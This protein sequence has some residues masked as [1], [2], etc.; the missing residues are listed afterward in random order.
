MQ[1]HKYANA[2]SILIKYLDQVWLWYQNSLIL[3]GKENRVCE[4]YEI[5]RG[6]LYLCLS[7]LNQLAGFNIY[8]LLS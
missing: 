4:V 6:V 1:N 5:K 3:G 2:K 8:V 7:L